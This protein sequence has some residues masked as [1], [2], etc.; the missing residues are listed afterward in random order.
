[1]SNDFL[2]TYLIV[3]ASEKKIY[4]QIKLR[5]VH[6]FRMKPLQKET[7]TTCVK[8]PQKSDLM[9]RDSSQTKE[10]HE[11]RNYIK[12]INS[13]L[14]EEYHTIW[15]HHNRPKRHINYPKIVSIYGIYEKI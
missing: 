6:H 9:E 11:K 13:I 10:Y 2:N 14:D 15:K 7:P 8:Q 5:P 3:P 1:M 4:P 12:K